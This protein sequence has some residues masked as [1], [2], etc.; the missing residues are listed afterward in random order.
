M[1]DY[2]IYNDRPRFLEVSGS[3]D[4]T[5]NVFFITLALNPLVEP[6]YPIG[7]NRNAPEDGN[8]IEMGSNRS[9]VL[10]LVHF[11]HFIGSWHLKT[12]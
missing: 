4:V 11:V 5:S 3:L 12:N 6:R 9:L 7:I 1:L 2:I 10:N 8:E